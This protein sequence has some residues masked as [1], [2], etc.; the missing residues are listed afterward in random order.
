M[1]MP[2]DLELVDYDV[3]GA[4]RDA[5]GVLVDG[6]Y[7]LAHVKRREVV[8]PDATIP[9]PLDDKGRPTIVTD[10]NGVALRTV[11]PAG[12][13]TR[14]RIPLAGHANKSAILTAFASFE[15]LVLANAGAAYEAEA[16]SP[17]ALDV[18]I[19]AAADAVALVETK[20]REEAELDARLAAKRAELAAT[21][22]VVE[23]GVVP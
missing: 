10:E 21:E 17:E 1:T 4:A 14:L 3:E 19:Q 13:L 11:T 23:E 15:A 2:V 5:S 22:A 8:E 6:V 9:V 20:R 12:P 7:L 16:A 18:K